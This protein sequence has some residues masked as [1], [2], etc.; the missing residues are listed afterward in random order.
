MI[1]LGTKA[2]NLSL[3]SA[4]L[5]STIL[6]PRNSY[7]TSNLIPCLCQ[8][9]LHVK[10]AQPVE[11]KYPSLSSPLQIFLM[12]PSLPIP[13]SLQPLQMDMPFSCAQYQSLLPKADPN[14]RSFLQN[15]CPFL[16]SLTYMCHR[17]KP[18]EHHLP[19]LLPSKSSISS[20]LY[21]C[22][23]PSYISLPLPA[24]SNIN[25]VPSM[26]HCIN[27]FLHPNQLFKV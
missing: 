7:N 27:N 2:P 12:R 3:L 24:I 1:M 4:T 18:M 23:S 19:S 26:V 14:V 6:L 20:I 22:Q 17:P 13:S 8:T 16:L 11:A 5:Q 9:T 10:N 25:C 21:C 15:L